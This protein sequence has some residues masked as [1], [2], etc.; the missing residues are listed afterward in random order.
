MDSVNDGLHQLFTSE[1]LTNYECPSC[2]RR[3]TSVAQTKIVKFPEVLV[4]SINRL[5]PITSNC[6]LGF[7]FNNSGEKISNKVLY[8]EEVDLGGLSDSNREHKYIL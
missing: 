7:R 2:N 6:L 3:G 4:I 1:S 8:P 5:K